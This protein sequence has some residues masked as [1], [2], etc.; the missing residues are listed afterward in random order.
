M[1]P[2]IPF[3]SPHSNGLPPWHYDRNLDHSFHDDSGYAS[4][5]SEFQPSPSL[6]IS[7]VYEDTNQDHHYPPW[8]WHNQATA[9][10]NAQKSPPT[11]SRIC[12][13]HH[14]SIDHSRRSYILPQPLSFE[15]Q[16][17]YNES[18]HQRAPATFHNR[19]N[20]GRDLGHTPPWGVLEENTSPLA[21]EEHKSRIPD[22]LPSLRKCIES[23]PDE[24][25]S[26][27]SSTR[28]GFPTLETKLDVPRT[29]RSRKSTHPGYETKSSMRSPA[30]R[31][32]RHQTTS[33][34]DAQLAATWQQHYHERMELD[35]ERRA[36]RRKKNGSLLHWKERSRSSWQDSWE[37]ADDEGHSRCRGGDRLE[38]GE[39]AG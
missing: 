2:F 37:D 10:I 27:P 28:H 17:N 20:F 12:H 13:L 36:S 15:Q 22:A 32:R 31:P 19:E 23:E 9:F 6:Y 18:G 14:D 39:Y 24:S 8:T 35:K 33:S 5:D 11:A 3:A 25:L 1:E 26:S 34:R 7:H 21:F 30:G 29:R 16:C 4:E 38:N